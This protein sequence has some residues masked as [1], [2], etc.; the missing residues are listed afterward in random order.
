[1]GTASGTIRDKPPSTGSSTPR[2]GRQLHGI[3][4]G[5]EY[6][7]RFLWVFE[8]SGSVPASHNGGY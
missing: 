8:I 2:P 6:H 3:R 7:G 4:W 1:M 5:E